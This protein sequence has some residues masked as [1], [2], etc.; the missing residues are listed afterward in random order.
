MKKMDTNKYDVLLR[1]REFCT[2]HNITSNTAG[3]DLYQ[4]LSTLLND[5]SS[6]KLTQTKGRLLSNESATRKEVLC[7][8]LRQDL[9]AIARTARTLGLP[10][11]RFNLPE[12]KSDRAL[13]DC[14]RSF[15]TE[16]QP[17]FCSFV[18]SG[19]KQDFLD[20][21]ATHLIEF[22]AVLGQQRF[23]KTTRVVATAGIF[24]SM[25]RSREI[26]NR[27]D[28]LVHNMFAGNPAV[29]ASWLKTKGTESFPA[30]SAEPQLAPAA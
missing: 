27:L 23:G 21:L 29:L 11:G 28:D 24:Y 12:H 1:V 30:V 14:A 16:A 9:T 13:V 22:E 5:V 4:K 2:A 18:K 15:Y 8:V 7:E 20:I 10:A 17:L 26:L 25:D 3:R 19:L 6:L